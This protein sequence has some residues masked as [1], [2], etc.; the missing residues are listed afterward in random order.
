MTRVLDRQISAFRVDRPEGQ[1]PARPDRR[2]VES[3]I[4]VGVSLFESA[5]NEVRRWQ[6]DVVDWDAPE[7]IEKAR[8]YDTLYRT[9]HESLQHLARDVVALEAAGPG[10]APDNAERLRAALHELAGIV[11]FDLD[12]VIAADRALR[13]GAPT[14]TTAEIR[15]GLRRRMGS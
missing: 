14:R 12:R 6:Q 10:S 5:K 1:Q 13:S 7:T 2:A 11:C 3:A 4:D 8:A 9:L 15:D